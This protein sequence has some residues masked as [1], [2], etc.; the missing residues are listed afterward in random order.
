MKFL[1]KLFKLPS[2]VEL[3]MSKT[4]ALPMRRFDPFNKDFCWEDWERYVAKHYPVRNLFKQIFKW[5]G[6]K[7]FNTEERWYRFTSRH[8][9]KQHL[10]DL[11]Q[12]YNG[13]D[14][15]EYGYCGPVERILY[16]NFNILK[17]F[18]EKEKP[19][20]PED[21][22]KEFE[23]QIRTHTEMYDLYDYWMVRRKKEDDKVNFIFNRMKS[24]PKEDKVYKA[25]SYR[26]LKARE[27]FEAEEQRNLERL[28]KIRRSMWQ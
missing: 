20:R 7:K 24:Y 16:A 23:D 28:I 9:K 25:I 19:P 18:I 22:P 1:K 14:V 3:G 26:W 5:F 21:I 8:F 13:Y 17:E 12:G 27:A 10:L 2:P 15:Y 6:Q 11:R 4:N